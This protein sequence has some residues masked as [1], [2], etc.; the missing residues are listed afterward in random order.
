M[1]YAVVRARNIVCQVQLM[2]SD[3]EDALPLRVSD[4]LIKL[5]TNNLLNY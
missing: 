1:S 4:K 5:L 2:D 3:E